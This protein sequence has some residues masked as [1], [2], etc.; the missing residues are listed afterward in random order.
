MSSKKIVINVNTSWNAY[1]FR[2]GLINSLR[3]LNYKV[4]VIAPNDRYASKLVKLGIKHYHIDIDQRGTNPISDY[5]VIKTYEKLFNKIK[6]D[7]ILSYTIKPNIYGNIAARKFQIPIINNIS[8]LGNLFIEKSFFSLV[9][10]ILYKISLKYSKWIFFQ[11]NDDMQLF[12][13]SKIINEN[14]YSLIQGSGINT[15]LFNTK[16]DNNKAKSFLFSGRLIKDKGIY[17]YLNAAK[18]ILKKYKNI[19]FLIAG[20]LSSNDREINKKE[21]NKWLNNNI[22]YLGKRD[23]ILELYKRTDVVILPSYREGLSKT[24]LEASSM[25]LPIIT[26]NTPGCRDVVDHKFNGLLAEPRSIEDL[27]NKIIDMINMSEEE[28]LQL[29]KNGRKLAIKKFDE[30]LITKMYI[31]KINQIS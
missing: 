25:S 30:K 18:I 15:S 14:K 4:F 2:L 19:E 12:V 9:A 8:G 17:E 31:N 1:N 10:K 20:E 23:D 26:T 27:K 28:R 3:S 7:I 6:P 5:R 16:R 13:D 11:N 29:G 21:L 22:K 24:L